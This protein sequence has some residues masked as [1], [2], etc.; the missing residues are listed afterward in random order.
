MK[1]KYLFLACIFPLIIIMGINYSYIIKLPH[2]FSEISESNNI[3]YVKLKPNFLKNKIR[4]SGKVENY[5]NDYILTQEG[6]VKNGLKDGV[7]RYYS[8]LKK[9]ERISSYSEGKITNET[10]FETNGEKDR[11]V[12]YTYNPSED[13]IKKTNWRIYNK[14][15]CIIEER[16]FAD[17]SEAALKEGRATNRGVLGSPQDG[18][19]RYYYPQK[20]GQQIKHE[21]FYKKGLLHKRKIYCIHGKLLVEENFRY[22]SLSQLRR[23]F[24]GRQYRSFL[25]P[26]DTLGEEPYYID[27]G[28][29]EPQRWLFETSKKCHITNTEELYSNTD[30]YRN[31][32]ILYYDYDEYGRL[33]SSFKKRGEEDIITEKNGYDINNRAVKYKKNVYKDGIIIDSEEYTVPD[34]RY[35]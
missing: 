26:E 23:F 1:I 33:N 15:G 20:C 12:Y 10:Y 18:Y 30:P 28:A 25:C 2:S 11:S 19:Q 31:V 16:S 9:I 22:P 21:V 27:G 8:D 17:F 13:I 5:K 4:Y 34:N 32:K 3:F 7:W 29:Y 6:Y 24:D 35:N 14:E